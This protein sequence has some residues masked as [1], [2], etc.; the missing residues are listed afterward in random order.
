MAA[1]DIGH[2]VIFSPTLRRSAGVTAS[3]WREREDERGAVWNLG[4]VR[5]QMQNGHG[6]AY[7]VECAVRAKYDAIII[8]L[9]CVH[10]K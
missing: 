3:G 2:S 6:A 1:R 8:M 7:F 4:V 5:P 10:C 9:I